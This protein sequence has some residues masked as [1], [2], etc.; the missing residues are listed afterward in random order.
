VQALRVDAL[1]DSGQT[2][3]G[4]AFR[5]CMT[6][7][8]LRH[9]R[10]ILVRRGMHY[11]TDDGI[12]LGALGPEEPL[13]AEG[14]NDVNENSVVLR[15]AYRCTACARPFRMLCMGDEGAQSEA[16]M[17]ATSADLEADV[18]K[19]GHHGSAYSSTP[20]FIAAIQPR[21]A[22]ISVGRRNLFG[23][24]APSTLTALRTVGAS[25]YRTD[26][27]GAAVVGP[28]A[29]GVGVTTVIGCNGLPA[30]LP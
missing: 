24:P 23:H 2:Y 6:A 16:R 21:Y 22:L 1:G 11:V 10:V 28:R 9:V 15:L 5:D 8:R 17:L 14:T 13:L 3:G 7:A 29:D 27:C 20:A 25:V 4:R 26:R 18:L 12:A 19:V 30:R